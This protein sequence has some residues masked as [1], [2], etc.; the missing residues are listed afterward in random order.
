MNINTN[1]WIFPLV[2]NAVFK[3]ILQY[4]NREPT[5]NLVTVNLTNEGSN[6][7]KNMRDSSLSSV[8]TLEIFTSY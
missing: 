5:H 6:A 2:V 1:F 7:L 3:Y 4:H 8:F